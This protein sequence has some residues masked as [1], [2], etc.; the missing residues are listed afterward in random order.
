ST[1]ANGYVADSVIAVN[2]DT[3]TA[4]EAEA[5]RLRNALVDKI[6]ADGH[7]RTPAVETALRA[8][9][10]HR[11]V[12][13]APL[14][15]A[16]A[17]ATVNIKY[18]TDRV[19]VSCASQPDI[20]ALMLDQLQAQPGERVL[21]LGAGTGYNAALIG[22]LV[23]PDGRVTTI[24]VDDDLVEGARTRLAATGFT[25]VEVLTGDGALGHAE[26]APYDRIIATVGAHGSLRCRRC[27]VGVRP[28]GAVA[29][30]RGSL[31]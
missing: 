24:D 4:S 3:L 30:A 27:G 5:E 6:Q 26:G 7:A 12:P 8:V 21:E 2:T 20:V 9:P 17:N 11:F 16:Y 14:A 29:A 15:D 23:G 18:D 10:R 19:P 31:T 1:A 22:H 25:N 13:Q 28:A